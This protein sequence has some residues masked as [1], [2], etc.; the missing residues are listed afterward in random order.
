MKR[1]CRYNFLHY[2]NFITYGA[3]LTF[4]QTAFR[5]GRCDRFVNHFGMSECFNNS[6]CYKNFF[7]DRAMTTFRQSRLRAGRCDCLV[8]HFSMSK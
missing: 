2:E 4:R 1:I 5:A 8:D 3:V 7:A 6:L